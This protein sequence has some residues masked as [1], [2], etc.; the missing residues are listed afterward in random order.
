MDTSSFT[1]HP[2]SESLPLVSGF[3]WKLIALFFSCNLFTSILGPWLMVNR[4]PLDLKPFLLIYNGLVFGANVVG[5]FLDL[6]V[7]DWARVSF[8]CSPIDQQLTD[9]KPFFTVYLAYIFLWL[10]IGEMLPR[11]V[12]IL[13][14]KTLKWDKLDMVDEFIFV[15][16]IFY[17]LK[18]FPGKSSSFLTLVTLIFGIVDYSMRVCAS[19]GPPIV[20]VNH[21]RSLFTILKSLQSIAILIHGLIMLTNPSC[22]NIA[23]LSL[24]EITSSFLSFINIYR[25]WSADWTKTKCPK[26]D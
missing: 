24:L 7:T 14:K 26:D 5:V 3:P 12:T 23:N 13:M 6:W 2:L 16:T 10:H 18:Y 25:N 22:S 20:N 4:Q 17:G 9:L 19:A 15:F 11:V 1:G 8:D 21:W